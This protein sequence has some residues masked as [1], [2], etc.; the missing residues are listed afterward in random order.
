MF[1]G[2]LTT[3]RR[4]DTRPNKPS[5][6]MLFF[7]RTQRLSA[8]RPIAIYHC[9]VV[10]LPVSGYTSARE[11]TCRGIFDWTLCVV[12]TADVDG[13][14]YSYFSYSRTAA[15]MNINRVRTS[16]RVPAA[17]RFYGRRINAVFN[18]AEKK[19][20]KNQYQI[21]FTECSCA[22]ALFSA[23]FFFFFFS[24]EIN[25]SK[26]AFPDRD[27]PW[28]TC[29]HNRYAEIAI[30]VRFVTRGNPGIEKN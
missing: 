1:R 17:A 6:K 25:P 30:Y 29:L 22:I 16:R 28:Q 11:I 20:K 10:I 3:P 12:C 8:N 13:C 26:S 7:F 4:G 19:K 5:W 21:G 24:L 9:P 15:S 14:R 23:L 2:T 18:C 27:D